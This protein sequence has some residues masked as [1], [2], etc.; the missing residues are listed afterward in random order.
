MDLHQLRCFL[1]VART[2]HFGQAAQQMDMLPSALGRHIRLLEESLGTRLFT[3]STRRVALTDSGILLREEARSLLAH[4]DALMFQFRQ[5]SHHSHP[6]L[7]VGAIDS[8]AVGLLPQLIQFFKIKYPQ[9]EVQIYEDK[10]VNL[11]P[12]ILHGRLDMAFIRPPGMVAPEITQR[13][14]CFEPSV[15]AVPEN[16]I[17]AAQDAI[18]MHQLANIPMIV[19]ERRSRPHS[20][21]MTMNLFHEAGI[22]A[23]IA[24]VANEKQTIINLVAAGMGLAIVPLWISR[25]AVN[26]VKF[27]PV[28]SAS[29]L[30]GLPLSVVW[31]KDRED[32][33]RQSMLQVIED[34]AELYNDI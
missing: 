7:R 22:E 16:H 5:K 31:L 23:S 6:L 29:N 11:L 20:H 28:A 2:L 17:L 1:T 14:L 25:F 15:V 18:E 34:H 32:D 33:T 4:A 9:V 13:F 30:A 10:T 26:G 3:R 27:L 8:A 21:D 24:Q 19:P 12:K